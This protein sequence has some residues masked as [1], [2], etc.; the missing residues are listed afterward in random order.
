MLIN[1][2][3]R[4]TNGYS[5]WF[6]LRNAQSGIRYGAQLA[7]SGNWEAS[8][9]RFVSERRK[10][11]LK[12]QDLDVE[13]G[14][15]F[16]G[17]GAAAL[18]PG[19]SFALPAVA[20]T[21][22]SGDL[23]DCANQ[24]HRYQRKYALARSPANRPPLAHLNVWYALQRTP[25]AADVMKYADYAADLGLEAAVID[26]GWFMYHGSTP[27]FGDWE[28]DPDEFP[29]GLREVSDHVHARGMK[30][31]VW[32]EIECVSQESKAAKEHPDWLLRYDGVPMP[33]T[34]GRLYL[35]FG[36]PEVR[37]WASMLLCSASFPLVRR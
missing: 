16:D 29:K 2:S 27:V 25:H 26:A 9:G 24:L 34:K 18:S 6:S 7:Y 23:D 21:A 5:A 31:G 35:N 20:F 36:K 13:M 28:A 12:D 10:V 32:L 3:G 1:Q 17:G 30:F 33:G 22:T 14:M 8:F 4:S 37:R 15:R 19:A 11:E